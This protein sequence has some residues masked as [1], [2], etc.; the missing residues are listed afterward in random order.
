MLRRLDAGQTIIE[1]L[2]EYSN[3][4]N[5]TLFLSLQT[6]NENFAKIK[7]RFENVVLELGKFLSKLGRERD[8]I[9]LKE[10]RD[11]EKPSNIQG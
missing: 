1:K 5:M 3:E 4:V 2:E 11:F 8:A 9:L 6:T 10:D 7:A